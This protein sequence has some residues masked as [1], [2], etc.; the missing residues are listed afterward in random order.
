MDSELVNI[1]ATL[2]SYDKTDDGEEN[3]MISDVLPSNNLP[4]IWQNRVDVIRSYKVSTRIPRNDW[5]MLY[6]LWLCL[7]NHTWLRWKWVWW[8]VIK[9]ISINWVVKTH[10]VRADWWD[11]NSENKTTG[12]LLNLCSQTSWPILYMRRPYRDHWTLSVH[13]SW[14]I[15]IDGIEEKSCKNHDTGR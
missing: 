4:E 6:N 11:C 12:N 1:T 9:Q 14:R 8:K 10:K 5:L 7:G 2:G 13:F 15:N 3:N